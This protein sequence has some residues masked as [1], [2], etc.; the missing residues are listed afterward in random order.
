MSLTKA[1]PKNNLNDLSGREW[2]KF[3]KSWFL[4]SPP[5]RSAKKILHPACFPES[6]AMSFIEFFTKKGEWVLDPFLG[7]GSTLLASK[8]AGR[9]GVGLEVYSRYAEIARSRLKTVT[10]NGETTRQIVVTEDSRKITQVF[11]QKRLPIIDFCLTSPPYWNQLKRST[12][13][14]KERE[15]RGLDTSYG[16]EA[17]DLGNIDNYE[18]FIEMQKE[19]FDEVFKLMKTRGYLVVITNNVFFQGKLYPLAFDTLK[20]LSQTWSPKDEKIWLQNDK[21]LMPLGIY[22]AWVGNR[23]HQYCMIFR[24]ENN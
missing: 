4:H 12:L 19:V 6:L 15:K 5:R 16:V 1:I 13:R 18:H 8:D 7:T 9:N 22:N 11:K 23:C 14:Q 21:T 3:T 20:T 17:A 24:K 10:V 2:I